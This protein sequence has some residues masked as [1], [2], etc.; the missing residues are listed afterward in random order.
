MKKVLSI[1]MLIVLL[2]V[3][4]CS[5]TVSA[6]VIQSEKPR[7]TEPQSNQDDLADLADGNSEFAFDLYHALKEEDG[8]LFY[9]PYSISQALAMTYA[10][11]SGETESQMAGTLNFNLA[12]SDLHPAFNSLDI[13]LASRGEGAK[14]K[15][16]EGFR[17]NIVN[18]I[19]GQRDFSFLSEFLDVLAENYGAG[20]R[21]L[22]F[23][24]ETEQS[25][26]TINDWVSEQTEE[27]IQD[28][29][30]PGVIT[31]MTRLVL[32]NA[33][34]FNAAWQYPFDED[35]TSDGSFYLLDGDSVSV[36]MMRQTESFGYTAGDG[37]QAV[38]LPY[39]GRELSMVI[40][41]P[42]DGRF[43]SFQGS[44]DPS[45]VQDIISGLQYREVRLSMPKFEFESGFG[46]K[47]V[48]ALMG[49]PV[50][51]SSDADFSGMTGGRD[52]YIA[53]VIHKAFVS[54]D[55][56]GTEAAAATAVMMELTAMPEKP[57]EVTIDHPFIFLIRDIET[58]T[59]LFV[60][61]V[62]NPAVVQLRVK[63]VN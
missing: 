29:I 14:G 50:A 11:A 4:S 2:G 9:S 51:F 53:E 37:Y 28:L 30:P 23:I 45:M 34:Y 16:G 59:V 54:V 42:E 17:L 13:E 57:I 40:L 21:I 56:A 63:K 55:E 3:S 10:G 19:W 18:A 49:M 22:D 32:T 8:N 5:Q 1:I 39:D 24:G 26:V 12:Q 48:L 20:L 47:E 7:D 43:G 62:M 61:R 27:R 52:L 31:V 33:I 36:P 25:R 35:S 6:E 44:M 46:L 38:E 15:D 58:G 41:L 60:G